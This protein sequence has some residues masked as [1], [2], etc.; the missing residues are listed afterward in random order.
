MFHDV[1]RGIERFLHETKL[2]SDSA[3]EEAMRRLIDTANP[4]PNGA[5]VLRDSLS[6]KGDWGRLSQSLVLFMLTY[7]Y[8]ASCQVWR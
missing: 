8:S 3:R 5:F 4:V 1:D 6:F 7:M 2:S